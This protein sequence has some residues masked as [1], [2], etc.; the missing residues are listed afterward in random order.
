MIDLDSI[1]RDLVTAY[2]AR[3]AT[4]KRK[5][6]KFSVA[7]VSALILAGAFTT[8]AVASDIGVNFTLDPTQWIVIG[9]GSSNDGQAAYVHAQKRSDGSHSTFM[10]EHDAGLPRYAAFLLHEQNKDAADATSPVPVKPEPGPLCTADQLT[11]AETLALQVA[12]ATPTK[13]AV[14]AAL[15]EEFSGSACRGLDYAADEALLV[16]AGTE[17]R[18]LL[19]P[20]AR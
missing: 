2:R 11:R 7:A 10:V 14:M 18:S 16:N 6:R 17:P 15:N 13:D 12:Q 4:T 9:S 5:R 20:G 1:E 19:M 3:L 8:V